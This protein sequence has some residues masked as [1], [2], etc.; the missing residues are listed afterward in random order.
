MR[1][2]FEPDLLEVGPGA[3]GSVL[4]SV[5]ATRPEPGQEISRPLTLTALDGTRRVDT[6]ITFQQSTSVRVEDPM[7]T[8]EV[9][10][11]LVRVRDRTVGMARVVANQPRGPGLGSRPGSGRAIRNGSSG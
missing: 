5:T 2:G 4:V 3:S 1:F 11:S 10:P 8:L 7:V 9:E 6:V